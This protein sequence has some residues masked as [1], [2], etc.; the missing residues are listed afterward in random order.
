MKQPDIILARGTKIHTHAKL[1]SSTDAPTIE[2]ATRRA[3]SDGKIVGV[4]GT[5]GATYLVQHDGAAYP[6]RYH[7]SEFDIIVAPAIVASPLE[8]LLSAYRAMTFGAGKVRAR[9]EPVFLG[10]ADTYGYSV[11]ILIGE[12]EVAQSNG[13]TIEKAAANIIESLRAQ[14][15]KL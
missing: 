11:S 5:D 1:G 10:K 15:A 2:D 6:S 13:D 3:D 4:S 12:T 8:A 9:V 14:G 7:Y